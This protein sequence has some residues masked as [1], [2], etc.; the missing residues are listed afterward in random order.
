MKAFY[1]AGSRPIDEQLFAG[2]VLLLAPALKQL[3]ETGVA[4]PVRVG[5]LNFVAGIVRQRL[6]AHDR[7]PIRDDYNLHVL[8]E[9][10]HSLRRIAG[11]CWRPCL[12]ARARQK[13]LRDLIAAP[14]INQAGSNVITFKDSSFNT[15]VAR[16]VKMPLYGVPIC[17]RQAAQVTAGLDCYGETFCTQKVAYALRT[18]DDHGRLRAGGHQDQNLVLPAESNCSPA[19]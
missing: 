1:A 7:L 5:V 17:R 4:I 3:A 14:K 12:P 11:Q 2:L 6:L 19:G 13:D 10:N 18:A 8:G 15:Q 16:K 9:V